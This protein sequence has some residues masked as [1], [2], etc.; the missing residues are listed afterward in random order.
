MSKSF[1][2]LEMVALPDTWDTVDGGVRKGS[3]IIKDGG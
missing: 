2:E 1:D 3:E